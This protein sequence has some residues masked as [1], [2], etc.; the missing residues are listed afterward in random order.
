MLKMSRCIAEAS[1]NSLE[2]LE[3]AFLVNNN[4]S[5]RANI[6]TA[7]SIGNVLIPRYVVFYFPLVRNVSDTWAQ[8]VFPS[9]SFDTYYISRS[10]DGKWSAIKK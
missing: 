2:E 9:G 10:W 1:I 7:F 3:S 5:L 4:N 8:G 6:R